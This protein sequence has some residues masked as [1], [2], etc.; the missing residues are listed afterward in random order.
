LKALDVIYQQNNNKKMKTVILSLYDSV[1]RGDQISVA[2]KRMKNTFPPMMIHMFEAGEK[3]GTIDQVSYRLAEHFEKDHRIKH[4]ISS[5]MIYPTVLF[6]L[7]ILVLI[8]ML[9]FVLP[10]FTNLFTQFD[11]ELPALTRFVMAL[12]DFIINNWFILLALLVGVLLAFRLLKANEGFLLW[13]DGLKLR[14]PLV[15]KLYATILAG[16]FARSLASLVSSGLPLLTALELTDRIIGNAHMSKSLASV[17]TISARPE[18]L[19]LS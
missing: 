5:A 15:G 19:G 17:R 9:T 4:T 10:T 12:S 3:S 11:A 7:T 6:V 1:Q 8:L 14:I 13:W 2:M 18:L 16:R